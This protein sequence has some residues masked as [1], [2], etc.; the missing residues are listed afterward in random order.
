MVRRFVLNYMGLYLGASVFETWTLEPSWVE[1]RCTTMDHLHRFVIAWAAVLLG[2]G[3]QALR[4]LLDGISSSN[5]TWR[6]MASTP[7]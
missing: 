5:S 2:F 4:L 1:A 3:L 6:E 7:A